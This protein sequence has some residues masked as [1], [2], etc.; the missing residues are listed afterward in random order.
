MRVIT[1]SARGTRLLSPNGQ[2]I[3]PTTEKVKEA[4]FSSIQFELENSRVLDLFAGSGQMGIEALSRG[5][6]S[7]VF[8]DN[9]K[10]AFEIINK[11][12]ENA[13]LKDKAQVFK[14]DFSTILGINGEKFDIC[15]LDPPYHNGYYEE[16][17]NALPRIMKPYG[18]VM[19][20][21]PK[22]IKLSDNYGS[23]KKIKEYR[24]SNIIVSKYSVEEDDD[25]N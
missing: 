22:D 5:A 14:T 8:C 11:N 13:K 25:E 23:L 16:V 9:S 12:L 24:F 6:L 15:F 18:K 7:A 3:R 17:L 1:G 10:D 20:E 19:C 4:I 21:H 2:D